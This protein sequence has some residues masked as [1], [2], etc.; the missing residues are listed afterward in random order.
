MPTC[1]SYACND[2]CNGYWSGCRNYGC[3][4]YAPLPIQDTI[5]DSDGVC[6][7]TV[8]R[9]CTS[10]TAWSY[11]QEDV[12][13]SNTSV[14]TSRAGTLAQYKEV[15]AGSEADTG[16]LSLDEHVEDLRTAINEERRRRGL[17][18]TGGLTDPGNF[19]WTPAGD[20]QGDTIDHTIISELVSNVN[21]IVAGWITDV[22]AL[23][24]DVI[25]SYH[26][27]R[28]RQRVEGLRK[29]CISYKVCAPNTVCS[30]YCHCNCHYSDER[31]KENIRSI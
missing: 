2:K 7:H 3:V 23:E 20:L 11:W 30:C 4:D 13:C 14:Y 16:E 25:S 28:I 5:A 24:D 1:R 21:T 8:T 6:G 27:D 15:T 19:T 10:V 18:A 9:I 29:D 31:L 26:I 12:G 22:E 17:A